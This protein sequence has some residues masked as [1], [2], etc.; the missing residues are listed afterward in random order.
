MNTHHNQIILRKEGHTY[1]FRYDD[2]N[3]KA[4]LGVLGRHVFGRR[5]G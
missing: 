4:L 5:P 3:C 1:V 2:Q